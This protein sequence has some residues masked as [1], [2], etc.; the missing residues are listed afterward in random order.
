MNSAVMWSS[1]REDWQAVLFTGILHGAILILML[2]W[3]MAPKEKIHVPSYV[4]ARLVQLNPQAKAQS[5]PQEIKKALREPDNIE[6]LRKQEQQ[7]QE[8]QK[9]QKA[10]QE[11]IKQEKAK[12][13]K[14]QKLAQEKQQREAA[15][16]AVKE[17]TARDKALKEQAEAERR[18]ANEALAREIAAEQAQQQQ[19]ADIEIAQSYAA[20]IRQRVERNWSRP[21]SARQG[22]E[23]L[24]EIQLVPAGYVAGVR[25]IKSSG[26]A[27]FDLSAE[28]AVKKVE[29]FVEIKELPSRIF[30]AQFRRFTLR[31][32]PEDKL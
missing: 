16:R 8:Q 27:A 9:Q 20:M 32:S 1:L 22:M 30:E 3:Q 6:Y 4:Q 26:N 12:Q 2:G 21:P 7:K 14:T 25:I 23:A 5:K 11:K 15:E 31:F 29:S 28:Q 18:Q 10:R 24:L 19:L 13:E 17:K